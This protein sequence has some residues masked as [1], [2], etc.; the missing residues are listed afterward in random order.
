MLG[1]PDGEAAAT[2]TPPAAASGGPPL[3]FIDPV[4]VATYADRS[5]MVTREADGQV[6]LVEF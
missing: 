2:Q 5:Q 3:L 6:R 4:V 1:P